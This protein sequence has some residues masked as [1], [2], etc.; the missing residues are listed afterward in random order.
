[1]PPYMLIP[2][3]RLKL[4]KAGTDRFNAEANAIKPSAIFWVC[5]WV[6]IKTKRPEELM[7]IVYLAEW[8]SVSVEPQ[9]IACR[10]NEAA[11]ST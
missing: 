2:S 8:T 5:I 1:M 10:L 4:D 6:C 3:W 9:A 11:Q 7:L